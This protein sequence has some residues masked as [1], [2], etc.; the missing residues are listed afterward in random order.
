M[1]PL[2]SVPGSAS[3][4]AA[5]P[6]RLHPSREDQLS[7]RIP[8]QKGDRDRHFV[9]TLPD[10]TAELWWHPTDT[11]GPQGWRVRLIIGESR[12]HVIDTSDRQAASDQANAVLPN[13]IAKERARVAKIEARAKLEAQM[14]AAREAG[15]VDVM[16]F[17]LATSDYDR[18]VHILDFLRTRGWLGGSLKPLAEAASAELYRRRTGGR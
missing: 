11:T 1:R 3:G 9:A 10:G 5:G 4:S 7:D 8:W 15:T 6:A 16:A 17:G 12:P 2:L 18:L 14:T 13:L